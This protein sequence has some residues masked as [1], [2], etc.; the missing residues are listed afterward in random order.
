MYKVKPHILIISA[1]LLTLTCNFV[2]T[3]IY[4]Y[5][6]QSWIELVIC[7]TCIL[8]GIKNVTLSIYYH[9]KQCNVFN[10]SQYVLVYHVYH[11]YLS[12]DCV[13]VTANLVTVVY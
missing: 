3:G 6:Y 13:L 12:Y 8:R 9:F 11:G 10:A 1:R 5:V 4:V 7:I 2:R